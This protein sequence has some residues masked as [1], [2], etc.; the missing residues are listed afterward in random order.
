MQAPAGTAELLKVIDPL[1]AVAV[2]VPPQLLIT[3]G[4]VATTR[5]AGR[6][7]VKLPL[8][9]TTFPLVIENVTVLGAFIATVVGL[10]L[11]AI[12]GGSKMMMPSVAVPPLELAK[13]DAAAV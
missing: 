12:D 6:L 10:K 1:P 5:L 13:P 2:T 9:G 11:F 7:S 4:V 8:I 3:V